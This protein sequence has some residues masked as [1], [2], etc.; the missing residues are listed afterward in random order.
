MARKGNSRLK[1]NVHGLV[2][3]MGL[4]GARHTPREENIPSSTPSR[5]RSDEERERLLAA[6]RE[7]RE[8]HGNK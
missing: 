3:R 2:G 5:A 8:I 7:S 4:P 1:R 6:A